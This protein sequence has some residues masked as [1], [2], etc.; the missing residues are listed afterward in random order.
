MVGEALEIHQGFDA[1]WRQIGLAL[2]R[3]NFTVSDRDRSKGLYFV[4]YIPDGEKEDEPGFF[5]KLFGADKK[6]ATAQQE[7]RVTVSRDSD[8]ASRAS[9]ETASGQKDETTRKILQILADALK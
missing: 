2:D 5:G 6:A 8:S 9:V 4:R 7:Y 1:A 3:S